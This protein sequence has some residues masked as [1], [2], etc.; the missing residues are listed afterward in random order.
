MNTN[1]KRRVAVVLLPTQDTN[2]R[3]TLLHA[4]AAVCLSHSCELDIISLRAATQSLAEQLPDLPIPSSWWDVRHEG[5]TELSAQ[6][7]AE[8]AAQAL[9]SDAM[10]HKPPPRIVLL[11]PGPEGLEVVARL[12]WKFGGAALGQCN[13]LGVDG[14]EVVA[15]RAAFGGRAILTLRTGQVQC[16]A[17]LRAENQPTQGASGI[18]PNLQTLVLTGALSLPSDV[19]PIAQSDPLPAVEGA[20][21]VV[22]GGRG[23]QGDEGFGLLREIAECLGAALGGSLPTVDAGWVSVA[24]Q[25]GQSGKFVSPRIYLAVGLSGTPQHLAGIS[26]TTRIVAINKDPDAAIF[27]VAAA[28]V[29]GDWRVVLPALL[30]RLRLGATA[31]V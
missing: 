6:G 26:G 28:G 3:H 16:F 11:P 9:T 30:N 10:A 1:A 14:A 25:I 18:T 27:K 17:T 31:S 2:E 24:R 15:W 29:V 4:A 7:L 5:L 12:A 13:A 21:I 8:V 19:T 22:S 23:M 20:A